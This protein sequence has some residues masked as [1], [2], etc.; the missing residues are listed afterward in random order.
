MKFLREIL[1]CIR[2]GHIRNETVRDDL[3]VFGI[4]IN[5]VDCLMNWFHH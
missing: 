1:G 5:I 4:L 2:I 3:N